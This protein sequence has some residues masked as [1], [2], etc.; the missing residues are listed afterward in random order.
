[1]RGYTRVYT[2]NTLYQDSSPQKAKIRNVYRVTTGC[3]ADYKLG[4]TCM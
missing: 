3:T 1:M 4:C 2:M